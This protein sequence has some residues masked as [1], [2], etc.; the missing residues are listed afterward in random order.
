MLLRLLFKTIN[1]MIV[2]SYHCLDDVTL[3][4]ACYSIH[5]NSDYIFT[6]VYYKQYNIS[7]ASNN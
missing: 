2:I 6:I 1:N 5:V 4:N 3:C 7:I